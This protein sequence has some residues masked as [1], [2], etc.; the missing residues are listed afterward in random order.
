MPI[1]FE[2]VP[3]PM[4][5]DGMP[6]RMHLIRQHVFSEFAAFPGV[7]VVNA[8]L[9]ALGLAVCLWSGW[10]WLRGVSS[11]GGPLAV[12][13]TGGCLSLSAFVIHIDVE[14]Y[15][16]VPVFF[17]VLLAAVAFGSL[18]RPDSEIPLIHQ[19]PPVRRPG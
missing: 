17:G 2:W 16:M 19:A 1:Q 3:E 13:L 4:R 18:E 14:R 6:E 15:Y 7:P 10:R 5:I 12:L 9:A 11:N 8:L